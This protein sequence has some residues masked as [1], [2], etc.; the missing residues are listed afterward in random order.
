MDLGLDRPA[1]CR[2]PTLEQDSVSNRM[3][4]GKWGSNASG[5]CSGSEAGSYLRLIDSCITQ[6]KAPGSSRTCHG[7][8]EEK[9]EQ[10]SFG[11]KSVQNL[12]HRVVQTFERSDFQR[13]IQGS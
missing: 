4:D 5:M 9:E 3:T 8:K 7:S 13:W 1:S 11:H 2:E 12:Q 10:N 6:L